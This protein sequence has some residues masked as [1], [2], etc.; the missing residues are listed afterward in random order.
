[1]YVYC[2]RVCCT[3]TWVYYETEYPYKYSIAYFNQSSFGG[4]EK[5]YCDDKFQ[6]ITAISN[7]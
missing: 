2:V 4:S 6:L 1:M 7:W 3:S 5:V